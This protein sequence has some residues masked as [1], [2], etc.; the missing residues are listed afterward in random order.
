MK[1]SAN[2]IA[3]TKDFFN[4]YRLSI[5]CIKNHMKGLCAYESSML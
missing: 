5:I 3:L 1:N 4:I 2:V